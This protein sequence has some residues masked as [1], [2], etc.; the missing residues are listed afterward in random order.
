[1]KSQ[2][3]VLAVAL[4]ALGCGEKPAPTPEE[5]A[6]KVTLP[7]DYT[8]K[9]GFTIGDMKNVQVVAEC[10]KRLSEHNA[11]IDEFVADSLHWVMPDGTEFDIPHDSAVAFIKKFVESTSSIKIVFTAQIPLYN[12]E[13]N[14]EWVASWTDETYTFKDGKVDHNN[15]H[16]TYR[17][18][19]GKI[20]E[21]YQFAQKVPEKKEP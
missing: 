5:T 8:Y 12:A 15:F 1:M 11:D 18:V 17:L 7:V 3:L 4:T 21:L 6:Q 19:N 20:R 14:H 10:N 13:N 9:G 16:E 2:L